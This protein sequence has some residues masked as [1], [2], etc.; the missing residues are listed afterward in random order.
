MMK[1]SFLFQ[2]SSPEA[3][4]CSVTWT[5]VRSGSDFLAAKFISSGGLACNFTLQA[6]E[7]SEV[8]EANCGPGG[9][10]ET[11]LVCQVAGLRPGTLYHL[12]AVSSRDGERSGTT[13][14]TGEPDD[15][16]R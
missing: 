10:S 8:H 15:P 11:S 16:G 14:R 5:E 3:S 7:D 4:R 6:T 1:R 12:T 2:L 13:V 9:A